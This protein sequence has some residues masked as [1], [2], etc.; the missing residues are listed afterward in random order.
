[1]CWEE[2]TWVQ[3]GGSK[4]RPEKSAKVRAAWFVLCT[5]YYLC[6]KSRRMRWAW[7]IARM[8]EKTA[9]G[10]HE[11]KSPLGRTGV[12]GKIILK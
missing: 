12:G 4:R 8:W 2:D 6:C 3:E 9:D 11:R 5:R 7:H 10:K 1:M